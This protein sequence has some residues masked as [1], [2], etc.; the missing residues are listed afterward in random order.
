MGIH[1]S[2]C[3]SSKM[4]KQFVYRR[5]S[6]IELKHKNKTLINHQHSLT[7]CMNCLTDYVIIDHNQPNLEIHPIS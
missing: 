1:C 6:S 3:N 7:R 4:K 2:V 5:V